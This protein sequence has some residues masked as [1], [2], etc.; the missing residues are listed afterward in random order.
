MKLDMLPVV[1]RSR[2]Y[3]VSVSEFVVKNCQG[4]V[5]SLGA[6][7]GGQSDEDFLML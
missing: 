4:H 2:E 6:D 3:F 5:V 1:K 7:E